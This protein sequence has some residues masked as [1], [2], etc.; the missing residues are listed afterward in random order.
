M[1]VLASAAISHMLEAAW[2]MVVS[3][4]NER[5][6]RWRRRHRRWSG[7]CVWRI[8]VLPV[9]RA[10]VRSLSPTTR[11]TPC[12]P[13][14]GAHPPDPSPGQPGLAQAWPR[15]GP[16]PAQAWPRPDFGKF[17]KLQPKHL[18]ILDLKKDLKIKIR[19]VKNVGK[20]RISREKSSWPYLGPSGTFFCVGRK[21]KK[22]CICSLIFAILPVWSP[23]CYP[24]K[25]GQ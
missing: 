17:G 11:P 3:S 6:Q 15:P 24:P 10:D 18:E 4:G 12:P 9:L 22:K 2:S 1:N 16:S 25:V 23:C 19:S 5:G 8:W 20:V 13:E 14:A 21:N 7:A